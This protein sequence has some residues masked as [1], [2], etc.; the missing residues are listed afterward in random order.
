MS[1]SLKFIQP[2]GV[3]SS[4]DFRNRRFML[5]SPIRT[6]DAIIPSQST[7]K[8]KGDK[9]LYEI[10]LHEDTFIEAPDIRIP[11]DTFQIILTQDSIGGYSTT[12]SDEFVFPELQ[13][14]FNKSNNYSV[15]IDC[16]VT[17]NLKVLAYS[18]LSEGGDTSISLELQSYLDGT[19]LAEFDFE[20]SGDIRLTITENGK[21]YDDVNGTIG[22]TTLINY[23]TIGYKKVFV[24]VSSGTSQ[25][26]FSDRSKITG[27]GSFNNS[28]FWRN[29]GNCPTINI[30]NFG[31]FVNLNK[32]RCEPS[33]ITGNVNNLFL[34]CNLEYLNITNQYVSGSI[35]NLCWNTNLKYIQIFQNNVITGNIAC[36][37]NKSKLTSININSNSISGDIS[38][39][40]NTDQLFLFSLQ[41]NLLT[42]NMSFLNERQNIIYIN[43][44][45]EGFY[46]DLDT[47]AL[48]SNVYSLIIE[49]E[50]V[51]STIS[52][53][54]NYENLQY[55]TIKSNNFSGDISQFILTKVSTFDITSENISF[56]SSAPWTR[57]IPNIVF[58][59][60]S[61]AITSTD[62]D[63]LLIAL[64]SVPVTMG[65]NNIYIPYNSR[66][67]ASDNA[68]NI[69]ISKGV[70]ININ[71][72]I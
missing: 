65:Y 49:S 71:P 70:E 55:L 62:I 44:R 7:I 59:L 67:H 48:S 57:T 36:L 2:N 22:E 26:I 50:N 58:S 35:D 54:I 33:R 46:G 1:N 24:K 40:V 56:S 69:L 34:S 53:L 39:I 9:D 52:N 3:A 19:G 38:S 32:F 63:N 25:I 66:T 61:T 14:E 47:V 21:F 23:N 42:G 41:G 51:Y 4:I 18:I 27:L 11:F 37:S 72:P 15:N 5:Q 45:S 64:S 13:E 10:I 12:F 30:D 28:G 6:Y 68:Y 17:S 16:F 60:I 8:L 43:L 20:I 29:H 31:E